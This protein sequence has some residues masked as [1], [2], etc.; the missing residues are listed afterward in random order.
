[1]D[2]GRPVSAPDAIAWHQACARWALSPTTAKTSASALAAA[3]ETCAPAA[4]PAHWRKKLTRNL[5]ARSN[6][7]GLLRD[8]FRL[9][10]PE[11]STS[12]ANDHSRYGRSGHVATAPC[13]SAPV[14]SD[15]IFDFMI[16]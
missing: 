9:E 2:S 13:P 5:H 11:A 16:T 10:R 3:G 6:S 8:T 1:M 4:E 7:W 12:Y 15:A 14:L